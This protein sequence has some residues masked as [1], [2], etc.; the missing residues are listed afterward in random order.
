MEEA[1]AWVTETGGS[2]TDADS[3]AGDDGDDAGTIK[4]LHFAAG[5]NTRVPYEMCFGSRY[6]RNKFFQ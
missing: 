1:S 3:I 2:I 6:E 5:A 4:G